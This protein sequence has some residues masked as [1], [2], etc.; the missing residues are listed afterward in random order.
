YLPA[1]L[2]LFA[3]IASLPAQR[4]GRVAIGWCVAVVVLSLVTLG[5]TYASAANSGDWIRVTRYLEA[6]ERAGEPI[7]VFEAENALPLAYYSRGPNRIVP[8]PQAVDFHRYEVS[9]FVIRNSTALESAIPPQSRLWLVTA[10][11]CKSANVDF[12]CSTLERFVGD[13]YRI[14][15][16]AA[17][18]G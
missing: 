18:H 10:G 15:S 14:E 2:S 12:G 1:T 4:R 9:A 7:V 3:L 13:R 5:R 16:D 11:A 17:F 8:V 6:H